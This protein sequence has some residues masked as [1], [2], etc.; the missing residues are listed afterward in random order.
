M[1]SA[2]IRSADI[3][4]RF[5]NL[6]TIKG[7]YFF[8]VY[9]ILHK[10][11]L[12]DV[13]KDLLKMYAFSYEK[14]SEFERREPEFD[15]YVDHRDSKTKF[16]DEISIASARSPS[17]SPYRRK[18]QSLDTF[19]KLFNNLNHADERTLHYFNK[20]AFFQHFEYA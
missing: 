13:K 4:K 8:Q 3:E 16:L 12:S 20:Y 18:Y 17:M 7:E 11:N 15:D 1:N 6:T 10:V 14:Y 19:N 2:L 9:G 5:N